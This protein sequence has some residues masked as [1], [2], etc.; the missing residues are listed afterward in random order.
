MPSISTVALVASAASAGISALGSLTQGIAGQQAADYNATVAR[1]NAAYAVQVGRVKAEDVGLKS[2]AEGGHI[3]AVQA[4]N[5][6]DVNSGSAVKVQASQRAAG[7][8]DAINTMNDALVKAYGYNAQ[9]A[10]DKSQGQADL[11]GGIFGAA[12]D[13]AK[14]VAN[15]AGAAGDSSDVQTM[16]ST[17]SPMG[18]ALQATAMPDSVPDQSSFL[19]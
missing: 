2:A 16:S 1:Q 11:V 18:A 13:V 14:G 12:G 15:I 3:K 10:L 7:R 4:A 8:V 19:G 9:A 6:I 5:N 17:A